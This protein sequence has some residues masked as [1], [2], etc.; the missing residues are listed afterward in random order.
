MVHSMASPKIPFSFAC[1]L[2]FQS[3]LSAESLLCCD[4]FDFL[5]VFAKKG[6]CVYSGVAGNQLTFGKGT[7]LS[8]TPSKFFSG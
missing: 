8:V 2:L 1:C 7:K 5:R 6:N 3:E 4:W